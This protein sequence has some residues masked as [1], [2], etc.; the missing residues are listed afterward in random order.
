MPQLAEVIRLQ[1]KK[2]RKARTIRLPELLDWELDDLIRYKFFGES[3]SQVVA[4]I[5]SDWFFKNGASV[6]LMKKKIDELIA[7]GRLPK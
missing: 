2:R 3:T 4:Y 6:E 1:P 7:S 5:L